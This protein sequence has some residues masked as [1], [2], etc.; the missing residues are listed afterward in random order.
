MQTSEIDREKSYPSKEPPMTRRVPKFSIL[1]TTA[2]PLLLGALLA[3]APIG[4]DQAGHFVSA[5]VAFAKGGNG[6]GGGNGNAGGNGNGGSNGNA[7]GNGASSAGGVGSG[8]DTGSTQSSHGA[9]ASSLGALNAA[10]ASLTGLANAAPNSRV[11]RIAA[12]AGVVA[13]ENTLADPNATAEDLAAAQSLLDGLS[14]TGQTT[15]DAEQ[16]TL[17]AAAN[18][19]LTDQVMDAVNSMLGL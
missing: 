9:L 11:G 4:A 7:G 10:H 8:G 13:A 15:A 3:T 17:D 12:Y 2:V 1:T 14:S 6:N 16:A 5:K 19:T 18:K